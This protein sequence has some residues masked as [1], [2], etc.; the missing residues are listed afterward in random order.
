MGAVN[1]SCKRGVFEPPFRVR[2]HPVIV[3]VHVCEKFVQIRGRYCHARFRKRIAQLS[4]VDFSVMVVID[5]LKH[6]P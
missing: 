4:F 1:G 6:L 5:A 3:F 2:D